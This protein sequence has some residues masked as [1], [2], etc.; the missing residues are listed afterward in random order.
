MVNSYEVSLLTLNYINTIDNINRLHSNIRDIKRNIS[1][2]EITINKILIRLNI[3]PAN[4]VVELNNYISKIDDLI[5]SYNL[6]S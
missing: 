4:S 5:A 3:N 2:I 6:L 1:N